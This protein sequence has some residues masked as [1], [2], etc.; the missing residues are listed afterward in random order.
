[1]SKKEK[2]FLLESSFLGRRGKIFEI[3]N[4][5]TLA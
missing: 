2:N 4:N 1:M 3:E 5:P